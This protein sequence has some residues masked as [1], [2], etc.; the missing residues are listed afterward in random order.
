MMFWKR[1]KRE[2]K[3]LTREVLVMR[4]KHCSVMKVPKSE[5]T[6]IFPDGRVVLRF[7][8]F[9]EIRRVK[10]IVIND[11]IMEHLLSEPIKVIKFE[12]DGNAKCKN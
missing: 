5:S 9:T 8:G 1:R 3:A 10:G 11:G 4:D 7:P 12:E 6:S 2:N